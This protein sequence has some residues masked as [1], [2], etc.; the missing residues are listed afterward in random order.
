[1]ICSVLINFLLFFFIS[2]PNYNRIH[3]FQGNDF[4]DIDTE[5]EWNLFSGER[6]NVEI[7]FVIKEGYHIQADQVL[8]ENLIPTSLTTQSPDDIIVDD[9]I[10]PSALPFR[11]KNV[12][13]VMMVFHKKLNITLPVSVKENTEIGIYTIIGNLHYQA[14]DSVKCYFPRDLLFEINVEVR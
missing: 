3:P 6:K 8:D 12:K 4:V 9:P 1:M 10:F 11:L 7:A 13:E 14:C 2:S 5:L